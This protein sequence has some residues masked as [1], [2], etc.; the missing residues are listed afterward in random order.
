MNEADIIDTIL[1]YFL[2]ETSNALEIKDKEII[3]KFSNDTNAKIKVV[4]SI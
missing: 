2:A 1:T 3:V 4:K